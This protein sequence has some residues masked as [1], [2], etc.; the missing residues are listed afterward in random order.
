[1]YLNVYET[2][3]SSNILS[4]MENVLENFDEINYLWSIS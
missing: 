1:M 3:L 2:F 4:G